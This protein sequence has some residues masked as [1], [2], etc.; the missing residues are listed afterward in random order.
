MKYVIF[1]TETTDLKGEVIQLS[2]M[3]V[4]SRFNVLDFDSFYCDTNS[5]IA[6]GAFNVHGINNEL[7]EVLSGGKFLEDYLLSDTK[8]RSL[9]IDGTG[10][11][12]IGYNV[13]YDIERLNQSLLT[14]GKCLT[15]MFDTNHLSGLNEAFSYSFDLMKATRDY[16]RTPRF[17]KLCQAVDLVVKR[18]F[19]DLDIDTLYEIHKEKFN[20]KSRG[21]NFH[22]ASYDVFCTYMLLLALNCQG[23]GN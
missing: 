7:L 12:F 20:L 4:D 11:V 18:K 5:K 23:T 6:Q 14:T 1:D 3:L 8:R 9:F 19:P 17:V 16:L 13:K 10:L 22:D 2:Y 15:S 21:S